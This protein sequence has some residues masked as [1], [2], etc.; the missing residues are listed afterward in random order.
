MLPGAAVSEEVLHNGVSW[1][2]IIQIGSLQSDP[3]LQNMAYTKM[4]LP[5][6]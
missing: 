3:V 4:V 2:D 1:K 5:E 6:A